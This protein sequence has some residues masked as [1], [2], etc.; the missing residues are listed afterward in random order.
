MFIRKLLFTSLLM[1]LLGVSIGF[2]QNAKTFE[3]GNL[4]YQER[5]EGSSKT[6]CYGVIGLA[7]GIDKAKITEIVVPDQVRALKN[8]RYFHFIG[9][10]RRHYRAFTRRSGND[11]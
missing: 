11:V 9:V 6:L 1:L 5:H 10:V 8:Y 7:D 4:K 3:V 2:G